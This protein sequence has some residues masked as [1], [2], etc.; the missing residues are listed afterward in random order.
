MCTQHH[1]KL[2]RAFFGPTRTLFP[3]IVACPPPIA[4]MP[5]PHVKKENK[6]K[7]E[8]TDMTKK[9][10]ARGA[11]NDVIVIDDDPVVMAIDSDNVDSDVIVADGCTR[12][13]TYPESG[14][15]FWCGTMYHYADPCAD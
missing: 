2:H 5:V 8:P 7:Q 11:K 1:H 6:V 13:E 14:T 3:L 10:K 12:C 15:C 9:L 4:A